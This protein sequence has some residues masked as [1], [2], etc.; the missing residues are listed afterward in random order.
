MLA[1]KTVILVAITTILAGAAALAS[2]TPWILY[3]NTPS[4][5]LGLYVR[6]LDAHDVG[7]IVAFR[8]PEAAIDYKRS[9]GER[10]E[11]YFLF[12][13]PVIAGPGDHVCH[14]E[15]G[16]L[17][18]NGQ[19]IADVIAD[20]RLGRP[21]PVWQGCEVLGPDRYF[22]LSDY[23][24]NSFD[25]RHF[26]PIHAGDILGAYKLLLTLGDRSSPDSDFDD[27]GKEISQ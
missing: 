1:R 17:E 5:P 3:P 25:S 18:L 20:D 22:T 26:G 8:V 4:L 12:M 14:R 13:K 19:S 6:T 2:D 11:P 7:S 10:V 21:L 16:P 15:Q 9:I 24:P 23:V 27:I